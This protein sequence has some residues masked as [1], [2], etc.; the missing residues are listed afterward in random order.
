LKTVVFLL[1]SFY[2]C[3]IGIAQNNV[4]KFPRYETVIGHFFTTYKINNIYT[5]D[6]I[7]FEKRR[8]GWHFIITDEYNDGNTSITDQLLWS[9]EK[10]AFQKL[11]LKKLEVKNENESILNEFLIDSKK[12]DFNISPYFGYDAWQED[13][14]SEFENTKNL[15]DTN[16]YALGRAYGSY[17]SN[18]LDYNFASFGFKH[19]F[20][21]AEGKNAMSETQLKKYRKYRHLAIETFDLLHK[22]NPNFSTI[23]GNIQTKKSNEYLRGFLELRIYQNEAEAEK[24]IIP[25]L[26]D[27]F[28]IA[29]AKNYLNSCDSNAILFTGGDNDTYPL[30]YV[31]AQYGIRTDI[32]VVNTSLLYTSSYVNSLREKILEAAPIIFS[33]QQEE[34]RAELRQFIII[35]NDTYKGMVLKDLINFIKDNR[36]LKDYAGKKYYYIPSKVFKLIK[37]KKVL[38]WDYKEKYI[39]RNHL[40]MLDI[41][42]T[43][44]WKR[45]IYFA[46]AIGPENYLGLSEYLQLEGLAFQLTDVTNKDEDEKYGSINVS[47]LQKN[48]LEKFDWT[49]IKNQSGAE[50]NFSINYRNIF[51]CWAKHYINNNN[52]DSANFLLDKGLELV[53]NAAAKFN[54]YIIPFIEDYYEI[55]AFEK[56]TAIAKILAENL[57]KAPSTLANNKEKDLIKSELQSYAKKYG[58]KD[59]M[60]L[61]K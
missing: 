36:N 1:T 50:Q 23:V 38:E 46:T 19:N 15:S 8:D 6:Q 39:V 12:D 49:A 25:D 45:P 18:L 52:R 31:Q 5:S 9:R 3:L 54:R 24:E 55:A 51:H 33:L 17:A 22:N 26:Y 59:L 57:N 42:A 60:N 40:M 7:T 53:P 16:L 2:F 27:S 37:K 34:I 21:L 4:S 35:E 28:Q 43:N 20:K 13:V 11:S 14:I 47:K 61:I 29:A 56:G 58:Q 10:K 44:N 48:V 32:Q 30:L 41:I